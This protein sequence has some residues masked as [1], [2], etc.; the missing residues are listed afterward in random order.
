MPEPRAFA[1]RS[2]SS[3]NASPERC[4]PDEVLAKPDLAP[5]VLRAGVAHGVEAA[6]RSL[7]APDAAAST[8]SHPNVRD[9]GR[10]PLV[11]DGMATL[12][13]LIC[14]TAEGEYFRAKGSTAFG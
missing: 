13:V 8:A 5:F 10:R 6:L 14:P 4:T 3:K 2:P 12:I 11:R 7:S 9:D 1:V